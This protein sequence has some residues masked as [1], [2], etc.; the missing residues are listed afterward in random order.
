MKQKAAITLSG[1]LWLA[2]GT[3]LL[4]KG[5]CFI[6]DGVPLTNSLSF[7]F[8]TLFG[9][10]SQAATGLI[11]TGLLLGFA[12]GRLIFPKTVRRVVARIQTLSTPIRLKQL[13]PLS[14]WILI[15][16]MV[17]LGVLMRFLPIPIDAR[18]LIDV[19]IGS[20]LMNGAMLYFRAAR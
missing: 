2:I 1:F 10:S 15:A 18:G 3:F 8:Q 16:S 11:A 20:A 5:L 6:S 9:S 4:Y 17:G 13:Y 14:Y 12:K 19:A 7:R